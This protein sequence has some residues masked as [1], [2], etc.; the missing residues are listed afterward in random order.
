LGVQGGAHVYF[1]RWGV[2]STFLYAKGETTPFEG[3]PV[4]ATAVR[5]MTPQFSMN[6]GHRMGWSYVSTGY[7]MAQITS[8]AA[9]IGTVPASTTDSGW[10]PAVSFGG[11]ARWFLRERLGVGFDLRWHRLPAREVAGGSAPSQMLFVLG[12]GVSFQ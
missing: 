9:A 3:T 4:V 8:E 10:T 5:A 12:V 11:G 6:F 1:G 2:G 7:G